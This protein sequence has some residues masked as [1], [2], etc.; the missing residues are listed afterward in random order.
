MLSNI[1]S[2]GLKSQNEEIADTSLEQHSTVDHHFL[3][4]SAENE[5]EEQQIQPK[6][7]WGTQHGIPEEDG[8]EQHF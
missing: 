1:L 8:C 2:K 7:Q 5:P 3:G 4:R 6:S